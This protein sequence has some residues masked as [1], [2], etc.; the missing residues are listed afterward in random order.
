MPRLISLFSLCAVLFMASN[1]IASPMISSAKFINK[2]TITI[3]GDKFG[4]K[5]SAKPIKFDNFED[6]TN[7]ALLSAV[8]PSWH[9]YDGGSPPHS[10]AYSNVEKHSGS[11][12]AYNDPVVRP[13]FATNYFTFS[14]ATDTIFV[15]YWF[16]AV[17]TVV[18][19]PDGYMVGKQIRLGVAG[20]ATNAP[21]SGPG[22]KLS[23]YRANQASGP[24]LFYNPGDGGIPENQWIRTKI[25]WNKWVHIQVYEKL[26]N[27]A[28]TA[29]GTV[30]CD[31]VGYGKAVFTNVITRKSGYKFKM[32]SVWLGLAADNFNPAVFD[33][34]VYIDDIYIDNTQARVEIG[35]KD[36]YGDCTHREIQIPTAWSGNSITVRVNQGSFRSG[37]KAYLFVVDANGDISNSYPITFGSGVIDNPPGDVTDFK[38]QP[39]D[40]Q[41]VLSWVNP[42]DSDFK[43]TMIRYATGNDPYPATHTEGT[44]VCNRETAPGSSDSFIATGLENG[45]KYNFS[46]FTYDEAGNYS[47]TAHVSAIPTSTPN[48]PPNTP[49]G[50]EIVGG[51]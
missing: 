35:D 37:D 40:G 44:L 30:W 12:S 16:K 38:A 13:R 23:D 11:L 39:G 4:I 47:E 22:L 28:G 45:T 15:S 26:S 46:A 36:S 1:S 5:S 24:K 10:A 48:P 42:T 8:D 33:L 27:P 41:I 31:C 18:G 19:S 25:P 6:G 49:T 29:N 32:D 3:S 43:G 17:S 2:T 21:Y 20:S 34:Q 51:H 7:G 9:E 14:P 50:L